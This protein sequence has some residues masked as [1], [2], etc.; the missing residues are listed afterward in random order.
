[1]EITFKH[2]D[3]IV[4]IKKEQDDLNLDEIFDMIKSALI[5]IS[6]LPSQ[7]DDYIIEKAEEIKERK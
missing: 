7:I 5:G 1:M 4:T 6:W 3:T 2:Y